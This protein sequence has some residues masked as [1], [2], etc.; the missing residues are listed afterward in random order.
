MTVFC[1]F[2]VVVDPTT[3]AATR[4]LQ[5]VYVHCWKVA[6]VMQGLQHFNAALVFLLVSVCR[7][8][9]QALMFLLVSLCCDTAQAL[10]FLLVSVC[11]DTAQALVF[12]LVSVCRDTAQALV[13]LLVSVCRDIPTPWY[14]CWCQ[15]V[16][17]YPKL[18]V[19]AGVSVS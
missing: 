16:V 18:G 2:S 1:G 10:V 19:L 7:D 8:T 3:W 9:A 12:L 15:C 14:S 11:C 5:R 4:R 17:T 6:A 13:F